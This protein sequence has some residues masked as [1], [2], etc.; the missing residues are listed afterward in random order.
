MNGKFV[1]STDKYKMSSQTTSCPRHFLSLQLVN[2]NVNKKCSVKG[3]FDTGANVS[4]MSDRSFRLARSMGAVRNKCDVKHVKINNA[5][6]SPMFCI[7]TYLIKFFIQ[8]RE[9]IAP[10]I[11][12]PDFCG[13]ALIGMNII[14]DFGLM[15]N[16][17]TNNLVFCD[18]INDKHDDSTDQDNSHVHMA[19]I[20]TTTQRQAK[21]AW[22]K[23]KIDAPSPFSGGFLRVSKATNI[24]PHTARLTKCKLVNARGQRIEGQRDII[25]DIAGLCYVL[26]LE[27]DGSCMLY[28]PNN[29]N[30]KVEFP[31]DE[32]LGPAETFDEADLIP[33]NQVSSAFFSD[34]KTQDNCSIDDIDIS[35]IDAAIDSKAPSHARVQVRDLLLSYKDI[36]SRQK[37]DLGL[38]DTLEHTVEL[39]D[40]E[41]VYTGQFRL[42]LDQLELV[43]E[44][45]AAWLKSGVIEKSRSKYNSPIFCVPKKEGHGLRV[46]LDY[47]KLNLKT[48]PDFYSI[49]TIE[50]CIEEIGREGSAIFSCIDLRSGFWQMKLEESARPYTAFTIPGVGQFQWRSAPMGLM[51]SPASFARLMDLIMNDLSNVIT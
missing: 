33:G 29:S 3:L 42:P 34:D 30:D 40:S 22:P 6:G 18:D 35:L 16:P 41:P 2:E 39:K 51:G 36:I 37:H 12:S 38:S 7:G 28:V 15:I 24:D 44:H 13:E 9:C 49:R 23:V 5:S 32:L 46:V 4:I 11:I 50:Q 48:V 10:F 14:R 27:Q 31:K 1:P 20:D 17:R 43:K 47:R 8:D 25:A 19:S 45:V 21:T 26:S